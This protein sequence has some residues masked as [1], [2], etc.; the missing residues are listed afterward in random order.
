[1][2]NLVVK[3]ANKD[4]WRDRNVFV[5]GSTGLIGGWVVQNLL[6][7]NANVITLVRDWI[8]GCL[9]NRNQLWNSINVVRG[10]I[11]DMPLLERMI[12]EYEVET[13]LHLAAQTIVPIANRNPIS[14]FETNIAG[15]WRLLEAARR[16]S[17]VKQI[18]IAS[19]DKAYG[20]V[21][22]LPYVE[23]TPLN[24][25]YPYDVSKSCTDLI[26][27][28][29]ARTWNLPVVIT[30]CGNFYGGG[31]L[32]WNR[33]V[34][35]TIRSLL[36]NQSPII[37]SNGKMIRDY[38]YAEDAVF[39][40]FRLAEALSEK[41][42]IAGHAFNFS[43]ENPLSVVEMVEKISQVLGSSIKATTKGEASLDSTKAKE[44]LN[45]KPLYSM[46]EGL[47]RTVEWYRQYYS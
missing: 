45:W 18:V 33:I 42:E 41:P 21:K 29:Y 31:D 25:Q 46:D 23:S 19:S 34:P 37:R 13:I 1:M 28:C 10:D 24:A 2:E 36:R 11:C 15:T 8:P 9:I 32:N 39:A 12:G 7:L 47:N 38:I 4:F 35:G 3:N 44:I 14:T 27:R 17:T 20:E 40:Y 5:T 22:E 16:N 6:E 26:S 30:R 43:N